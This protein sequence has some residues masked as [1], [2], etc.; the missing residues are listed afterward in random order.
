[1]S[2]ST[3]SAVRTVTLATGVRCAVDRGVE[4]F[5]QSFRR[6]QDLFNYFGLSVAFLA[7]GLYLEGS[8]SAADGAGATVVSGAVGFVIAMSGVVTVAQILA[9]ERSD[10]TVGRM[11]TIPHGLAT[12][13][14]SKVVHIVLMTCVSVAL[15]L[16]P[17]AVLIE[18]VELGPTTV[19]GLVLVLVLGLAATTPIG[20]GIGALVRSPRAVTGILMVPITAISFLSGV[21][22]PLEELPDWSATVAQAFPVL[23]TCLASREL[24][25]PELAAAAAVVDGSPWPWIIGVLSLWAALGA[26]VVP[27]ALSRVVSR[28]LSR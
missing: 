28:S 6:A 4:E 10:G 27:R 2:T 3:T 11:R 18:G 15:L 25:T 17:A 21:F 19:G 1:M 8:P 7:L 22:V 13:A 12:Y 26:A 16:V 24:L 9:A 23:W 5:V 14:A 20:I